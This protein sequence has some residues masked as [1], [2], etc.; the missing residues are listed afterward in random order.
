MSKDLD[1]VE[2]VDHL[3]VIILVTVWMK[4]KINI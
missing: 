4:N 2:K 1:G 3:Q